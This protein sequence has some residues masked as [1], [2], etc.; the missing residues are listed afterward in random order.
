[1]RASSVGVYRLWRDLGYAI[2]A[3]LAGLVADALGLP[4]A[5]WLVAVLTFASGIVVALRM[6]ETMRTPE[7]GGVPAM[8]GSGVVTVVR[9]R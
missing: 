8:D 5:M 1:W 3:L 9:T 7:G 2:G 4:A 6:S